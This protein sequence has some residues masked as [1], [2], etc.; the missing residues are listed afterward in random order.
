[1][2]NRKM[3]IINTAMY[4]IKKYGYDSFSYK[5]ISE[6]VGITKATLHHHFPKKED[7]GIAV[8]EQIEVKFKNVKKMIDQKDSPKEKLI[9][10]LENLPSDIQEGEICP[11]TSMQSE[12]NIIPE[13]MKKKV[14]KLSKYENDY[15]IEI[16]D[17]GLA[18]GSFQFK[19]GS[20]SMAIMIVAS[21]KGALQYSRVMDYD[22]VK[23]IVEQIY[24]QVIN[25]NG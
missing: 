18:D 10:L 4:Y 1:M 25:E 8:C 14:K 19:G 13:S 24:K 22:I 5:D 23:T 15:L 20:K 2:V 6:A 16:L 7:L 9:Y 12:F 17:E 3:Q 11:I 21:Y